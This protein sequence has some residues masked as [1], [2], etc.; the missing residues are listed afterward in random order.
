MPISANGT[1]GNIHGILESV[2]QICSSLPFVTIVDA[3]LLV[4]PFA[5]IACVQWTTT[6]T[7]N[8]RL[9]YIPM[10]E[11]CPDRPGLQD[12]QLLS[13]PLHLRPGL[14]LA[15]RPPP[16]TPECIV[17]MLRKSLSD[18]PSLLTR[19]LMHFKRHK[20]SVYEIITCMVTQGVCFRS[21]ARG[22]DGRRDTV[23]CLMERGTCYEVEVSEGGLP[24]E[25]L[26]A[27]VKEIVGQ[28]S[29]ED[30]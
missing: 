3:E 14:L 2:K 5:D 15:I 26:A 21:F 19:T 13:P 16:N 7:L 10:H 1:T 11:P 28:V 24:E 25:T 9:K 29:G 27:V 8:Q 22:A 17:P 12:N 6:T 18:I 23:A 30:E 20:R 4:T